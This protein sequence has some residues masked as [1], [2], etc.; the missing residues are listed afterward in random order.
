[1]IAAPE[2]NS[3]AQSAAAEADEPSRRSPKRQ[4]GARNDNAAHGD[5]RPSRSEAHPARGRHPAAGE[6]MK[7]SRWLRNAL[8]LPVFAAGVAG[9]TWLVWPE[10][11]RLVAWRRLRRAESATE[12][13][14][15]D[16]RKDK[17]GREQ[18]RPRAAAPRRT[19]PHA[20][21]RPYRHESP[22]LGPREPSPMRLHTFAPSG[23]N[24]RSWSVIDSVNSA[25]ESPPSARLL[26]TLP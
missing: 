4:R 25:P 20:L 1:M 16:V 3:N 26:A 12:R 11:A 15:R 23:T 5:D 9:I 2:G 19:P 8:K 7:P 13:S 14:N 17:I 24:Q 6:A 22:G 18:G 10:A 21:E